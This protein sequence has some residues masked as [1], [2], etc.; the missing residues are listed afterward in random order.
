MKDNFKIVDIVMTEANVNCHFKYEF[1]PRKFESHLLILS[2][3][4]KKHTIQIELDHNI[5]LFID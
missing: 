3:M 5:L 1:I 2:Y 4:I